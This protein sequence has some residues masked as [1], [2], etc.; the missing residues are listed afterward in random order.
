[1]QSTG[2]ALSTICYAPGCVKM[3]EFGS[4]VPFGERNYSNYGELTIFVRAMQLEKMGQR[5]KAASWLSS[6]R[7]AQSTFGQ[8]LWRCFSQMQS[9][10]VSQM[11]NGFSAVASIIMCHIFLQFFLQINI[12][13]VLLRFYVQQEIEQSSLVYRRLRHESLFHRRY[14]FIDDDDFRYYRQYRE[15]MAPDSKGS[16]F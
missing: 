13:D 6:T 14:G 12:F 16:W 4:S 10:F 7:I 2:A 8:V 9:F 3:D 5:A 15:L 1:M 11:R